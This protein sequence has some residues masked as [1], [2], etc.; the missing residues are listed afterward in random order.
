MNTCCQC[1]LVTLCKEFL[2]NSAPAYDVYFIGN[3]TSFNT[4]I[5][6]NKRDILWS[7]HSIEYMT[8]NL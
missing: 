1:L 5:L 4:V 6:L 2:A 3:M 7:S 8:V